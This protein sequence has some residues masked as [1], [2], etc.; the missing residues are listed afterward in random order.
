ME[1]YFPFQ[2]P[3]LPYSYVALMPHCDA[4]TLFYHHDTFF[5]EAVYELNHLVVRHRLTD[6][7]LSQL[8]TEDINLPTAQ[9]NR[10]HSAA[11]SV[12]NHQ[13]YFDGM[14]CKAGQPP[15]NRLTEE[16]ATTYGSMSRFQQLLIEAAQSIIGS[17][18]IWLVAEGDKGIHIATTENNDV[19][20]LA[21]VTPLLALDMWEHAY[22]SLD[23]FD[24]AHYVET[25]FSLINWEA[26]NAKY[27]DAV[28]RGK[29]APQ[30]K[31]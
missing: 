24:K 7:S 21:S 20:A 22:L 16:I 29:N 30:A 12:F 8:L 4:N 2:V 27:L 26:A 18:W 28:N 10:L 9:L 19:V 25:W 17:G 1:Q 15:F 11:G 31:G 6:R 13:F 23:H 5:A 14:N 3:A